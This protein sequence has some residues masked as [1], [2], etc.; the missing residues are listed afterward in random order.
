MTITRRPPRP[1]AAAAAEPAKPAVR[2]KKTAEA[3][4]DDAHH[5]A[6]PPAPEPEEP[7]K[8][9]KKGKDKAKTKEKSKGKEKHKKRKDKEAV[10]IRFEDDQLELVDQRAAALG[11]SR[12]AWVR[13]VVA[14]ALRGKKS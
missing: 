8:S 10:L 6:P 13:M 14:K 2:R 3:F 1:T 12:A 5:P 11:L 7:V 9:A 4:I